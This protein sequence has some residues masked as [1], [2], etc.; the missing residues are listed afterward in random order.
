MRARLLPHAGVVEQ[1]LELGALRSR[2][3]AGALVAHIRSAMSSGAEL[4]RPGS[5]NQL[6]NPDDPGGIAH[7]ARR[8]LARSSC[9]R[10]TSIGGPRGYMSTARTAGH[11]PERR[12][13]APGRQSAV[14]AGVLQPHAS[15]RAAAP[16]AD[17]RGRPKPSS[18]AS[19][20]FPDLPRDGLR[21]GA[22]GR[23]TINIALTAQAGAIPVS[24]S[25]EKCTR[26]SSA[27]F[28]VGLDIMA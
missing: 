23:K 18:A 20:A 26:C 1:L 3:L 28:R 13:A 27:S 19:P 11:W 5:E 12:S 7:A 6:A 16:A 15:F 9:R 25:E 24:S 14:S 21:P 4:P 8:A 17:A 2:A 22:D 10:S